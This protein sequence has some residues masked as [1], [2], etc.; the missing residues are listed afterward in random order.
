MLAWVSKSHGL[1]GIELIEQL[2][3]GQ[4]TGEHWYLRLPTPDDGWSLSLADG[5]SLP[6]HGAVS[7]LWRTH[8]GMPVFRVDVDAEWWKERIGSLDAKQMEA[9]EQQFFGVLDFAGHD[10]RTRAYPYPLKAAHDR[11]SL[12]DQERLALRKQVIEAAVASGM[13]PSAFMDASRMTGHG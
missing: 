7:Y 10:Y 4:G 12:I 2:A 9:A 11:A 8:R 3:K 1:P 5:R 13:K 6:P